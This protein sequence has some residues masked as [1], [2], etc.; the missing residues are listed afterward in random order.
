MRS[1]LTLLLVLATSISYSK[2][3]TYKAI[4]ENGKVLF[5]IEAAICA[6]ISIVA[7]RWIKGYLN[8]LKF[9]ENNLSHR[10]REVLN[11]ILAGKSNK[12]IEA[13]LF[14][15]KS[16]LK[17]HINRIYKKLDVSNRGELIDRYS[18]V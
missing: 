5:T 6:A 4:D 3:K 17:S 18:G 12:D 15:E 14:I 11:E 13:T 9:G 8:E 7:Y 1:L 2:N 10:E 16:T